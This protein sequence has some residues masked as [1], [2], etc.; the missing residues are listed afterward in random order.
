MAYW[1]GRYDVS[2]PEDPIALVDKKCLEYSSDVDEK[3]KRDSSESSA[4][5]ANTTGTP[6][7]SGWCECADKDTQLA[8]DTLSCENLGD[9]MANSK[10]DTQQCYLPPALFYNCEYFQSA[11]VN[12]LNEDT[13]EDTPFVTLIGICENIK[14][15]LDR[16]SGKPNVWPNSMLLTYKKGGGGNRGLACEAK[17][18]ECK[19]LKESLWPKNKAQPRGQ[20]MSCDEFPCMSN[21]FILSSFQNIH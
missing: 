19:A 8:N 6:F 20:T 9:T 2:S 21:P 15:Y 13:Y 1:G 14:K 10:R 4:L 16:N 7:F 5:V 12:N 17:A 18:A 3:R 11:I